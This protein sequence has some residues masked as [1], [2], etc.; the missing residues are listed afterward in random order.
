MTVDEIYAVINARM[1]EAEMLHSQL[2]DYWDFFGFL[3]GF[4]C[5]QEYRMFSEIKERRCLNEYFINHYNKLIPDH[6]IND[7]AVI[8]TAFKTMTRASLNGNTKSYIKA[9]IERWYTWESETKNL[10][11]TLYNEAL[12]AEDVCT[13]SVVLD[14]LKDVDA[15]LEVACRLWL[16]CKALDYEV[17]DMI[18]IQDDMCECYKDKME[19][20]Y[21][22]TG[23]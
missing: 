19:E 10:F 2:A 13:A 16:K 21:G 5:Q 6:D 7:P 14:I 4:K 11:T 1:V 3:E 9:G 17:S 12:T 15:E 8:P 22:Y 18:F 23:D 20:E